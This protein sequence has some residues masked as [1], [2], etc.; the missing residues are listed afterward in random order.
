MV[1]QFKSN[2]KKYPTPF[3]ILVIAT[4]IDRVGGY[5]LNPFFTLFL[6]TKF[7]LQMTQ[8]GFLFTISSFGGIFGGLLGGAMSDKFG[9]KTILISALVISALGNLAM[10]IVDNLQVFY[11]LILITGVFGFAGGPAQQAMVADLLPKE[12]Q[13]GGF[14][15]LRV[16]V[17]IAATVG[18]ILGGLMLVGNNFIILFIADA[19]FSCITALI[20]LVKIPETNPNQV[21]EK[22]SQELNLNQVSF[23]D[24]L[25]GYRDVLADHAFLVFIGISALTTL[26]YMQMY[27]TLSIYLFEIHNLPISQFSVILSLNAISVVLSQ[28]LV[29]RLVTKYAPLIMMGVGTLF[30]CVGYGMYGFVSSFPL[31]IVAMLIITIGEMIV[32][33]LGQGVVARLA[34]EDKRGRYMGVYMFAFI[35]PNLFG[36]L[37]AG[38]IWDHLGAKWVWYIAGIIAFVAMNGFFVIHLISKERLKS[39]LSSPNNSQEKKEVLSS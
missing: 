25:K 37:G 36:F 26:V 12:K 7:N 15:I 23:K 32:L 29:T 27:S 31:F 4:F 24:T 1:K 35:I 2:F 3:K 5:I 11:I 13:A 22:K 16:A 8:I 6:S 30:Y 21:K 38:L 10:G 34:P 39:N 18:P 33:P 17:N 19:V 28:F 20:V 9:R 14:G